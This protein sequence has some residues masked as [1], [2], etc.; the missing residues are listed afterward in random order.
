MNEYYELHITF[1]GPLKE[2][3]PRPWKYSQIDGDPILGDGV[4]AYLTRQVKANV[5]IEEV[6]NLLK[7]PTKWLSDLG[8]HILREK[9]ERV[10][11]DT[12]EIP[13]E[14]FHG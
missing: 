10:V 12:K 11:Y 3:P 7:E 9:I 14:Y 2:T 13:E 6:K 5:V 8:H 4:K 1:K